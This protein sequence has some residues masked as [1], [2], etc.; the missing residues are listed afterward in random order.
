[1]SSE[2]LLFFF[3]YFEDTRKICV[4]AD[5][6]KSLD[7]LLPLL[8]DKYS[9]Q[10]VSSATPDYWTADQTYGVRHKIT[11]VADIYPGAVLEVKYQG[12]KRPGA[13]QLGVGQKR[14]RKTGPRFVARLRGLP[15]GTTKEQVVEFFSGISLEECHIIYLPDGRASGEGIVEVAS[16]KELKQ[17]LAKDKE[18]IGDR[19]IEVRKSTGSD[20]DW[21]LDR[22]GVLGVTAVGGSCT[23][24]ENQSNSVVRM[25]GLPFSASE[26]D[27]EK[28]LAKADVKAKRVH[29]IREAGVGRPSGSAYAEVASDDEVTKALTLN[30]ESIGSRYIEMFKSSQMELRGSI[31]GGQGSFS[32]GGV[33]SFGGLQLVPGV[34]GGGM[35]GGSCIRMRGLPWRSTEQDIISF[36]AE[37]NVTPARIHRKADGGEAYVE[38]ADAESFAAAMKRNK[39]NMGHRYIELF[40]VSYGEVAQAVGMG[41]NGMGNQFGGQRKWGGQ[42]RLFQ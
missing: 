37:V 31:G 36:F 11:S 12:T 16:E 33:Q 42:F 6:L 8:K 28:F 23:D 25:R 4:T 22:V 41:M 19:Y 7:D 10:E 26:E 13:N 29:I 30:R 20:I 15:W 3:S 1:M 34:Q 27:I 32:S 5:E 21:A 14:P 24:I 38:F 40:P 17:V 2:G 18:N 9:D 39:A 35:G